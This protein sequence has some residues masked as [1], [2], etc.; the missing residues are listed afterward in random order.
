VG[1][2]PVRCVSDGDA[3]WCVVVECV[4]VFGMWCVGVVGVGWVELI[5]LVWGVFGT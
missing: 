3:V 5:V 2:D 4:V 1:F